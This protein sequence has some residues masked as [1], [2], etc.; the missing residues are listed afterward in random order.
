MYN[1]E[2][3]GWS[4]SLGIP[5]ER[6][7]KRKRPLNWFSEGVAVHSTVNALDLDV[8]AALAEVGRPGVQGMAQAPQLGI[9][10]AAG[11]G[12]AKSLKHGIGLVLLVAPV[13]F[14]PR[15]TRSIA[16]GGSM[17]E[18]KSCWNNKLY[19]LL[20]HLVH[21]KCTDSAGGF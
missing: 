5:R 4:L 15:H 6:R 20:V 9:K 14:G 8:I 19:G 17:G 10:A 11:T 2:N 3:V 12:F 18:V 16:K 21:L 1:L 7:T 13:S